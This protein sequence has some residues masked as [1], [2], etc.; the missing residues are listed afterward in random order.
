VTRG[1]NDINFYVVV[2]N[3]RV[4]GANGNATLAFLIHGIHNPLAHLVEI[5]GSLG[6]L[7]HGINQGG[8]SVVNVSNNSDVSNVVACIHNRCALRITQRLHLGGHSN[9][10]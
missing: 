10:F 5:S 2:D 1:I 9:Y 6:L 7:Q 4:L 3:R 8:F